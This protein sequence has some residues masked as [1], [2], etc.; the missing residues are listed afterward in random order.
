MVLHSHYELCCKGK[1]HAHLATIT[2]GQRASAYGR[3][4]E[5]FS[6]C[7]K[8]GR[9]APIRCVQCWFDCVIMRK[10]TH[11]DMMSRPQIRAGLSPL[12]FAG[13]MR[14]LL[15]CFLFLFASIQ[16][17]SHSHG[18]ALSARSGDLSAQATSAGSLPGS[19]ADCPLCDAMHSAMPGTPTG[20]PTCEL[21][22]E[23]TIAPR[24]GRIPAATRTFALFSRPPP[25]SNS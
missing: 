25:V 11:S 7:T 6:G 23:A 13:R 4:F 10:H 17:A 12:Y 3:A 24:G 15:C 8:N 20:L 18:P 21:H 9:M 5:S 1:E 2:A 16:Q 14:V 22:I 19:Q